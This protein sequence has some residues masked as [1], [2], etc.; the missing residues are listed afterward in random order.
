MPVDISKAALA[1]AYDLRYIQKRQN[2]LPDQ[3]FERKFYLPGLSKRVFEVMLKNHPMRFREVY[4]QRFVNNIYL[5]T[6]DLSNYSDSV[7]GIS[8]RMKVR[9]RWYGALKG[10][11]EKPRLE[12]KI[13]NNM[14]GAKAG[15]QLNEISIDNELSKIRIINL[16]RASNIPMHLL[17]YLK[18]LHLVLMNRY[19]RK[20]YRSSDGNYRITV[21]SMVNY[22][23]LSQLRN[24]F[25][26]K[27]T[28]KNV[29]IIELKY[30]KAC[31]K[32]AKYVTCHFP[33]RVNKISKYLEGVKKLGIR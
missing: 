3:R 8:K 29:T 7:I 27:A 31:D 6:F 19:I 28:N 9:L 25:S 21:D 4:P 12:L 32:Y 18:S 24:S 23:R 5:D 11:I 20:Y 10:N 2:F 17:L 26:H 1:I 22:Y 15:F 30:D 14:L 16:F 13:K 33:F